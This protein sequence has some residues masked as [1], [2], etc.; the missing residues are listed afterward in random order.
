MLFSIS[1]ARCIP[2]CLVFCATCATTR[3][4]P[5]N[6]ARG[7][8]VPKA[9]TLLASACEVNKIE[10]TLNCI[11]YSTLHKIFYKP[12]YI[13]VSIHGNIISYRINKGI[14]VREKYREDS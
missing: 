11:K 5:L 1:G 2:P 6:L 8:S 13:F 12:S 4:L 9:L 3:Q 10:T 7:S 14:I